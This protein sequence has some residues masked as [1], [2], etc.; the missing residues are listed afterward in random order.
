[1]K[2]LLVTL[3]L[4]FA[5][6]MAMAQITPP[7]TFTA[8]TPILSSQVNANFAMFADALNRTGGTITGNITVATGIT[9]D[10]VDISDL[11]SPSTFTA[12]DGGAVDNVPFGFADDPGTG[13]WSSANDRLDWALNEVTYMYL[14]TSG[15]NLTGT[16]T[17]SG[18]LTIGAS[19]FTVDASNGNIVTLGNLNVGGTITGNATGFTGNLSGDVTSV[20]MATTLATVNAN[21]G[22]FGDGST[23][24]V[25][26]VNAKGLVTAVSTASVSAGSTL[27]TGMIAFFPTACS[28]Y[29]G[30]G[31]YTS[32]RGR[33]VVGVPSGG[34]AI[35]TVGT[36]LTDQENRAVGQHNHSNTFGHTVTD[37]GHTHG[38]VATSSGD[39][40]SAT[41]TLDGVDG[42]GGTTSSQTTGISVSHTG[43]ISNEGST[44]GTNAPYIQLFACQKT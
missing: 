31:E 1:M 17:A 6:T 15:L 18:N 35:A 9:I 2:K 5:P 3:L 28:N 39:L 24:P 36:A 7:Y 42:Y 25:I 19:K 13:M 40:T 26:T 11:A 29:S 10:G 44:A 20:G 4:L 21:V 34:T 23:I 8:G 14:T 12:A 38:G 37:A 33:Y 30:W 41:G 27:P 43:S 16:L 22:S 32:A